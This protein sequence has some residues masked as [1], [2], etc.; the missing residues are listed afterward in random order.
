[1]A[2]QCHAWVEAHAER[3]GIGM[4]APEGERSPTVTAVTLPAGVTGDAVVGAVARRGIVIGG[5]YGKLKATTFRIGHM[6]DHTPATLA[7]CL[8]ACTE[9]LAELT[10][11]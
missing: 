2:A 1:M 11:R 7:R 6:G 4:L 10:G 5:G 3:F 8:D 9:A